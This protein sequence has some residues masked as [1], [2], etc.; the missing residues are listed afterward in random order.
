M[1]QI[2][3]GAG[4]VPIIERNDDIMILKKGHV[5]QDK[6]CKQKENEEEIM[7]ETI[8]FQD[9]QIVLTQRIKDS[10]D[11]R[12]CETKKIDFKLDF[13]QISDEHQVCN[14]IPFVY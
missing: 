10:H 9:L 1:K 3:N 7:F 12:A 13:I 2:F 8:K 5:Y 11:E 6:F 4:K 14:F